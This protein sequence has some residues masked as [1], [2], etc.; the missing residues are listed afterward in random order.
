MAFNLHLVWADLIEIIEKIRKKLT[1]F[2]NLYLMIRI[3]RIV[4]KAEF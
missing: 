3:N 4:F 1:I 2:V